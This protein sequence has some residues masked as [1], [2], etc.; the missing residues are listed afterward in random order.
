MAGLLGEG[1]IGRLSGTCS[2]TSPATL[3]DFRPSTGD[4]V[5]AGVDGKP[6]NT[7]AVRSGDTNSSYALMV[8]AFGLHTTNSTAGTGTAALPIYDGESE[9]L[10]LSEHANDLTLIKGWLENATGGAL[11]ST[12]T[13]G[14][15]T[16]SGGV[17]SRR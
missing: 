9:Y 16:V 14:S 10:Q 12:A 8:Q 15:Y 1:G 13:S 17:I 11:T 6:C 5:S 7:Y 3:A 2:S 4:N